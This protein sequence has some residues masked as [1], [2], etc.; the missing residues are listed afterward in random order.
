MRRTFFGAL[1]SE[2]DKIVYRKGKVEPV[3]GITSEADFKNSFNGKPTAII[4]SIINGEN[5]SD[6]EIRLSVEKLRPVV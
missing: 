1:A 6:S 5:V 4:K 3:P 2:L